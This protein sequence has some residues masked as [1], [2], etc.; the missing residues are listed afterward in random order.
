MSSLHNSQLRN[1]FT[2]RLCGGDL[3]AT[4]REQLEPRE[5]SRRNSLAAAAGEERTRYLGSGIS[6]ASTGCRGLKV[7][8]PTLTVTAASAVGGNYSCLLMLPIVVTA[9]LFYK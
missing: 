9:T 7:S 4:L 3:A 8:A 5:Q 6:S 2:I 1:E